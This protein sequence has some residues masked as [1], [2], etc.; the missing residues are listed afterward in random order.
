MLPMTSFTAQRQRRLARHYLCDGGSA[1]RLDSTVTVAAHTLGFPRGQVNILDDEFQYTVSNYQFA[2]FSVLP[3]EATM[4]QFTIADDDVLAVEDAR[5]DPRFAGLD[6]V[7]DGVVGSY[8]GVPLRGRESAIVGTLCVHD[9]APHAISPADVARMRHYGDIAED[10]LDVLRRAGD[11]L[12]MGQ[13][14][15]AGLVRAIEE[16]EIVPWYQPV[17][18][19]R[20]GRLVGYEALARWQQ[21]D[22]S[23]ADPE[24]FLGLAEDSDVIVDLDRAVMRQALSDVRRWRETDPDVTVSMNISTV[25]L[26]VPDGIDAIVALTGDAGLEADAIALELTETRALR[27]EVEGRTVVNEL[28]RLGYRVLLDDFGS[29]WSSL[30]WVLQLDVDGLKVDRAVTAA[31]GSRVGDAVLRALVRLSQELELDTVVEGIET[32]AHLSTARDLGF[33]TGQG[34]FWSAP[35][36]AAAIDAARSGSH[37]P[38]PAGV[39]W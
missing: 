4:C 13:A 37:A 23:F 27:D 21:P 20:T 29:G 9:P 35:L 16:S 38:M 28:R 34:Y 8:L 5:T 39:S 33:G 1:A 25:H 11:G 12:R 22:G 31:M 7:R 18:D 14:A 10:Q 19:L 36:P 32:A 17:M 3:R 30:D 6:T 2:D 26:E 24:R 15:V